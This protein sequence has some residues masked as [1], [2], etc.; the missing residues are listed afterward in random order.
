MVRR[1]AE[2]ATPNDQSGGAGDTLPGSGPILITG[3]GGFIGSRLARRLAATGRTVRGLDIADAARG[4]YEQNGAELIVGDLFDDSVLDRALDGADLV[5][6]TAARMGIEDDWPSYRHINV[7]G[8][9]RV[10][11]ASRRAGVR[12]F[13]H[14]SSVMVYGFDYPDLVTEDGPLDGADNPYCQ[15]KIESEAAVLE[16]HDPGLFDVFVK[17]VLRVLREAPGRGASDHD[18]RGR[19]VP[20]Y[21]ARLDC[22]PDQE[23]EVLHREGAIPWIRTTCSATRGN[24]DH[25]RMGSPGCSR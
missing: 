23:R 9:R 7:D 6:H 14:L 20:R 18:C 10:V 3:G 13:V 4:E 15:T 24:G 12:T 1:M 21:P 5:I 19:P 8:P 2:P 25:L 16:H 22:L 17:R 11:T